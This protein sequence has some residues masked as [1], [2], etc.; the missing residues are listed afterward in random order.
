MWREKRSH[1]PR[2]MI[3]S[4]N[5]L[6]SILEKCLDCKSKNR[7]KINVWLLQQLHIGKHF[8]DDREREKQSPTHQ[9]CGQ[10]DKPESAPYH[11][12][13]ASRRAPM[14]SPW[15]VDFSPN[16][17]FGGSIWMPPV[18]IGIDNWLSP[19]TRFLLGQLGLRPHMVIGTHLAQKGQKKDMYN[20]SE[21]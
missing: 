6:K 14:I 13:K 1:P 3:L 19:A 15:S 2:T 8:I 17:G 4:W 7:N 12:W 16:W 9:H 18:T 11:W 10:H 21:W 20:F 5:M